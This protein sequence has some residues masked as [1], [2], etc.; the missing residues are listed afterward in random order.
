M[1]TQ[2]K[3]LLVALSR[4]VNKITPIKSTLVK[5]KNVFCHFI[6]PFVIL[7]RNILLRCYMRYPRQFYRSPFHHRDKVRLQPFRRADRTLF[8]ENTHGGDMKGRNG[9]LSPFPQICRLHRDL[10]EPSSALSCR[11][12]YR[13]T[14]M[15]SRT[16]F[17][18]P[19]RC[20]M[21]L[22]LHIN[23]KFFIIS[24]KAK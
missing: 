18:S 5:S 11:R 9:N 17:C 20:F 3:R 24:E 14:T 12:Y 8:C 2:N 22:I 4:G 15:R 21:A 16:E 10:Q 19:H 13:W 7:F 1:W 23:E 6:H